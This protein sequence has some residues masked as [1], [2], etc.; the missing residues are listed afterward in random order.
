MLRT[1][2]L[3]VGGIGR[4][5]A[6]ELRD[7][8]ETSLEAA[9]DVNPGNLRAAG[10]DEGD[11]Y[12]DEERLYDE[13]G[14]RLDAV[15]VATPPAFHARQIREAHERGLH[16]LCEKPLVADRQEAR[17]VVERFANAP[18]T[19]MV[20]YQRHLD[21]AFRR[22]YERWHAGDREPTFL[23]GQL[24]QDWT[25]HFEGG[26][27]WR[28]DPDIGVRGH[29]FSVGTHVLES[30][31]WM[32]GL[33]PE[34]VSAEMAFH[35]QEGRIDTQSSLSIRFSNGAIA[36]MADSAV[37]PAQ[38]EHLRIWDA[39][40]ALEL[41]ARDWGE[42]TLTRID[43]GGEESVVDVNRSRRKTKVAAFVEAVESGE[44]PPATAEDALR[45]T[46]LLD[47]AY[48]SARTGER[49]DVDL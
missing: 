23:T 20:C 15:V 1:A 7:H 16:V 31:L 38:R 28:T 9:A 8:P 37:V 45:V 5:L 17:A 11:R 13:R 21:P 24:T 39:D 19:L 29:L 47:A 12:A 3:G 14:D 33:V 18:E 36:S 35:D 10:I 43:G 44:A 41:S 26:E 32:T 2:L 25:A 6:D 27:N 49:I 42:P 40:G 4:R 22:G 30:M 34:S 48:E 46:A